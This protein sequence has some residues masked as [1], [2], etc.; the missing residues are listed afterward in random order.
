MD[1]YPVGQFP[2]AAFFWPTLVAASAAGFDQPAETI[3]KEQG[4]SIVLVEQNANLHLL[5]AAG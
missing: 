2:Y 3:N 4:L 5:L 1:R